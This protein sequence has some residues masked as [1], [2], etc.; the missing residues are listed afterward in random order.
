MEAPI[1]KGK[2]LVVVSILRAGNGL[3]EGMLDLMPSARVGHIGIYRDPVTLQPIEYYMKVPEDIART[4]GDRRRSDARHRQLR[5]GGDHTPER[6]GCQGHQARLPPLGAGG[7]S[8]CRR[9][10]SRCADLH[11]CR[12]QAISTAMATSC[13]A[14]A[15]PGTECSVQNNARRSSRSAHSDALVLLGQS[16]YDRPGKT[17]R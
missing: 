5:H 16:G 8:A 17:P 9:R 11:R 2:K 6:K 14:S 10:P 13:P 15:M 7:H 4:P 3:L 1:L 12:R